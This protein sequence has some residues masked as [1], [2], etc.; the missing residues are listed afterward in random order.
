[1]ERQ[2]GGAGESDQAADRRKH[3]ALS[4]IIESLKSHVH[5]NPSVS[6][7]I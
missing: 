5:K 4:A 6:L 1:M 7:L 3:S 2:T